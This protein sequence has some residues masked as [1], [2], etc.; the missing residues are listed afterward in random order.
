MK[1]ENGIRRI[2]IGGK[3]LTNLYKET[4]SY[5]QWN[6]MDE[7]FIMNEVK[8][9][10]SFISDNFHH[11][12]GR[13]ARENRVG[14]RWYDREFVLP[15]FVD[16][17]VGSVRLPAPLQR[18]KDQKQEEELLLK[19]SQI[20]EEKNKCRKE[21]EE[22]MEDDT[23]ASLDTNDINISKE[24]E[25]E[26]NDHVDTATANDNDND[27]GN[28]DDDNDDDNDDDSDTEE[29]RMKEIQQLKLQEKRRRELEQQ[30]Q[31]VL[32][33]SVERFTVPEVLFHPQDIGLDQLGIVDAIVQS[34]EACDATLRAAMY[35]NILLTGGNVKMPGFKERLE[36]ELRACAPGQYK[37]SITLPEDPVGYPWLG[38][39]SFAQQKGF[40]ENY[41]LDKFTWEELNKKKKGMDDSYLWT[42]LDKKD[43]EKNDSYIVV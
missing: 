9:Q 24:K 34:I 13:H 29:Q 10:T 3:L 20:E 15:N 2:N 16:T 17:F 38:A 14:F 12:L 35:Q 4:V 40:L 37:V 43:T 36:R 6:M 27:N 7:F 11:D 8:E 25:E 30:E 18:Q 1:K 33:V 22:N 28:D 32:S 31:Q 26:S 19:Q 41:S 42:K 5:R 39:S 21:K 23:S